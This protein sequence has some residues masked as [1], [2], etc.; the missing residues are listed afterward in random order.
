MTQGIGNGFSNA[1]GLNEKYPESGSTMSLERH[2]SKGE[3]I[4]AG[5][6]R[7]GNN[8]EFLHHTNLY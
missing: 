2:K 4:A 8:G 3:N 6:S 1:L 7:S 5:T